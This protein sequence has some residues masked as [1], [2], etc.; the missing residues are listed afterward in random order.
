[1]ISND[2]DVA[3][4]VYYYIA[5]GRMS[6]GSYRSWKIWKVMELKNFIFRAWTVMEN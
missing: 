6:Q 1:M 5:M 2:F 3:Y 4:S